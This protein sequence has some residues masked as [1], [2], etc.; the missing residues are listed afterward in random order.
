MNKNVHKKPITLRYIFRSRQRTLIHLYAKLLR[1]S[2]LFQSGVAL[3]TLD[4]SWKK[5]K[6]KFV[7]FGVRQLIS[8]LPSNITV[9][10]LAWSRPREDKGG[11]LS[12]PSTCNFHQRPWRHTWLDLTFNGHIASLTSSLLSTL[13]QINSVR[14]FLSKDVLHIMQNSL[15]FSKLFYCSTVRSGTSKENIHKLQLMQNFAGRILANTKTFDHITPVLHEL[16][17][18]T[19]EELLFLRDVTMI[20]KCLNGLVPSYLSNKFVKRNLPRRVCLPFQ[21]L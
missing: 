6:N 2:N 15:V 9:P 7:L 4:Q 1:I 21:G 12:R 18:L 10:F 11:L 8:E 20:F 13:V 5:K 14:H 16:G 3:T 19:I 17:W